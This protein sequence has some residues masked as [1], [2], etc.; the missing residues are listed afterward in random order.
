MSLSDEKYLA[1]TTFR[2]SGEGVVTPVWVAPLSDGRIGFWTADGSGKTK[3]MRHTSRVTV[4]ASDGAGRTDTQDLSV[5]VAAAP[6]RIVSGS[7]VG[8]GSDNRAFSGL[9]FTPVMVILLDQTGTQVGVIRTADMAGDAA[10]PMTGASSPRGRG[11]ISGDQPVT[12]PRSW[13]TANSAWISAVS[14]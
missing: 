9:G 13:R 5:T 12:R 6:Q 11:G 8:D 14:S 3:R 1:L 4:Q 2:R 7:F 10:K